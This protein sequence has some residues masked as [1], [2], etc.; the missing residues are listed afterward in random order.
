MNKVV[1]RLV[2]LAVAVVVIVG[3]V[4]LGRG[5]EPQEMRFALV[6]KSVGHT[7]WEGVRQGMEAE[8]RQRGVKAVF[9]GPPEASVEQQLKIIE[10]LITQGYDG[11]GISPSDSKAVEEII[12][13]AINKGIAVVTFDSDSKDSRR[14]VYIGTDNREAGRIAG[15]LMID[16][17]GAKPQAQAGDETFLVQI[18]GGQ[19]G[20]ENLN[21]RMEG[22]KE[23][24]AD[25]NISLAD[26]LYNE[27]NPD[28]ALQV[29]ENAINAHPDLD[30]FFCANAFG[31]PGVAPAIED[32]IGRGQLEPHQI[33]VVAFDTTPDILNYIEEGVIDCT[34]AQQTQRMG[35]LSIEHLLRFA[36][37]YQELGRFNPPP[38]GEDVIDTGVAVVRP[39]DV[40]QYRPEPKEGD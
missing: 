7:Y 20:A 13:R 2:A 16:L 10:S 9:Q 19:P 26:D 11:I 29:A 15:R 25:V 39:E 4:V 31:G 23:A 30:G 35:K 22:F 32:A 5:K 1:V 28:K 18:I 14:L 12:G 8:A 37:Q 40:P 21:E 3:L 24:V 6:P 17:L 27:E 34:L 36:Q 38:E 33:R